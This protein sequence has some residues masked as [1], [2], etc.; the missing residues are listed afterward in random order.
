MI[1]Q[2]VVWALGTRMYSV[3][4][5]IGR[6]QIIMYRAHRDGICAS[7]SIPMGK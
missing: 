2:R 3:H 7:A 6:P 5:D 1:R 4:L